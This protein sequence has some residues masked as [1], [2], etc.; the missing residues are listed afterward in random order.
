MLNSDDEPEIVSLLSPVE[1]RGWDETC[2][3]DAHSSAS[4]SSLVS[5]MIEGEEEIEEEEEEAAGAGAT[6][7]C[8]QT[9]P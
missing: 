4:T 6:V 9:W 7:Q 3:A 2:W 1:F 5:G 8:G